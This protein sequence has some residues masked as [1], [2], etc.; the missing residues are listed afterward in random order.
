MKCNIRQHKPMTPYQQKKYQSELAFRT[1]Q[2]ILGLT[3]MTLDTQGA[4]KVQIQGVINGILN[5]YDCLVAKTITMDD[6]HNYL[7][8]YG[9]SVE[10]DTLYSSRTEYD[11]AID[12]LKLGEE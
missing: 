10:G 3:V 4:T 11:E 12:N 7:E 5:Q 2:Y 1:F 9:I 8:E 6:I